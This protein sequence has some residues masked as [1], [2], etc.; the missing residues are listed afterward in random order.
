ML[1][2]LRLLLIIVIYYRVHSPIT[3]ANC[4]SC[5]IVQS[6]L[7]KRWEKEKKNQKIPKI[8]KIKI[9]GPLFVTQWDERSI[10]CTHTRYSLLCVR[11][12]LSKY[13]NTIPHE[14]AFSL[15]ACRYKSFFRRP[16][17]LHSQTPFYGYSSYIYRYRQ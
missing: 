1:Y 5:D 6:M 16:P 4:T 11:F 2:R 15:F 9:R 7:N 3:A 10:M 13:N 8:N 17:C 12:E 14:N